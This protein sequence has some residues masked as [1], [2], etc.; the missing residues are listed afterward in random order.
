MFS[1]LYLPF[2][3]SITIV[4]IILFSL[5][6]VVV[7]VHFAL[8]WSHKFAHIFSLDFVVPQDGD[9]HTHGTHQQTLSITIETFHKLV[10]R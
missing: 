8:P 7:I 1:S 9:I 6:V 2:F 10:T 3:R 4:Y 5:L